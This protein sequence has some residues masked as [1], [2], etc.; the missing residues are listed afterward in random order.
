[1]SVDEFLQQRSFSEYRRGP[2]DLSERY[3]LQTTKSKRPKEKDRNGVPPKIL[4]TAS[5][6]SHSE[7]R[8]WELLLP[9]YRSGRDG[10]ALCSV[11]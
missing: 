5:V 10:P 1:M 7:F 4:G 11:P 2:K 6:S 9:V 3:T 8:C